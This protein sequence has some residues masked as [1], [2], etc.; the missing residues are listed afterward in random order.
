[1]TVK[2]SGEVLDI[3]KSIVLSTWLTTLLTKKAWLTGQVTFGLPDIIN[4]S[5]RAS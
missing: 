1:M 5:C 2:G 3:S 4:S